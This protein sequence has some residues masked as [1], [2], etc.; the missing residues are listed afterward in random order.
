MR[1]NLLGQ[2]R[3]LIGW[4]RQDPATH[5]QRGQLLVLVRHAWWEWGH[6]PVYVAIALLAA[7]AEQ[8]QPLGR[9]H[10]LDRLAHPIHPALKL[11][12]LLFGE[13]TDDA[14]DVATWTDQRVPA[15]V[16]WRLRKTGTSVSS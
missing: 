7:E 3:H 8:V 12:V 15:Q 16:G 2:L 5:A 9:D 13:A 10:L 1:A 14:F 11:Q 4:D 6:V